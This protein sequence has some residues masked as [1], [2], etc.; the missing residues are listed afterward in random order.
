[1]ARPAGLESEYYKNVMQKTNKEIRSRWLA[2]GLITIGVLAAALALMLITLGRHQTVRAPSIDPVRLSAPK[3]SSNTV[4]AY[5]VAPDHPKYITI[6]GIKVPKTRII[7]L[8]TTGHNQIAA[9]NNIYDVGWYD[10][11]SKPGRPGAMFMYGHVSSW[12]AQ[13]IFYNLKSLKA[14]DEITLTNGANQQFVYKVI[15]S[16]IY[17]AQAVDM[18]EVLSPVSSQPGLNLMT[19]TGNLIKGTNEFSERLVVFTALAK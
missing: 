11:S 17:S 15:K 6:P 4:A 13:G 2:Y 7:Q 5:N 9:P 16:K 10:Q 18:N 1:M 19:C 12:E 14:G 3:P 8:G